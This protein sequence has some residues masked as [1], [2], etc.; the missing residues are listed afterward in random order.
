MSG[1]TRRELIERSGAA[2]AAV[3]LGANAAA[4]PSRPSQ[5]SRGNAPSPPEPL[6][7]RFAV[8]YGM[9]GGDASM[10]AKFRLLKKLGF[11]GVEM[12]SPN[13]FELEDVLAARDASG[14]PVHGVVDSIHWQTR[15]SDPD[16]AVREQGRRGLEEAILDSHDYGGSSVL[17]VPGRVADADTEN[18]EQ[19]WERSIEQIRLALPIAAELGVH[20]LIENVWNGF[21]YDHGG[22]NDQ[23]ADRLAAYIDAI[24]S[25]WVGMYYDLGNHKKYGRVEDWVRTLGH[26]IVKLDVKDWGVENGWAKIGQGDIDWPAVRAAL[27]EIGFTGWCTA[28]VGGGDA[29]RLGEIKANMDAALRGA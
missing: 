19:V 8:K 9:V 27:A 28:E 26:R 16:P 10:E 6:Q 2:A 3:A 20:I 24:G 12:D 21:C 23:T 22:A 15:L 25:P 7:L 11:D 29:G 5:S 13:G 18:Q 17:L 1:I 14:L 4:R